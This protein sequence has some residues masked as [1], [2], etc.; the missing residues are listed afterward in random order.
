MD[1]PQHHDPSYADW[2]KPMTALATCL[3]AVLTA[4]QQQELVR[5][6]RGIAERQQNTDPV[7]SWFLHVLAGDKLVFED[8]PKKPDLKIVVD[9]TKP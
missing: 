7:T 1:L 4:E 3:G 8:E 5:V 2:W 6:Y 9:N